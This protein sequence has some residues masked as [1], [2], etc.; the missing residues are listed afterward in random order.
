MENIVSGIAL[1]GSRKCSIYSLF[2]MNVTV[3][4]IIIHNRFFL[5]CSKSHTCGSH[6]LRDIHCIQS[7]HKILLCNVRMNKLLKKS[8]KMCT[9]SYSYVY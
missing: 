1:I 4:R 3:I 8:G 7:L 5:S 9:E 6:M 2:G